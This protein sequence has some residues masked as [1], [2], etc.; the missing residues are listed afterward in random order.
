MMMHQI[1]ADPRLLEPCMDMLHNMK[2]LMC[3]VARATMLLAVRRDEGNH[4]DTPHSLDDDQGSDHSA[5]TPPHQ[6]EHATPPPPP[7]SDLHIVDHPPPPPLATSSPNHIVDQPSVDHPIDHP[8]GLP[9]P[10]SWTLVLGMHQL[11]SSFGAT[12]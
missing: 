4:A 6:D 11:A 5:S 3:H 10:S 8:L 7:S 2:S 9:G 12:E 1:R